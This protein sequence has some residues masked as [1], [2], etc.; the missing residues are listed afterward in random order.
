MRA[1]MMPENELR[2]HEETPPRVPRESEVACSG[3]SRGREGAG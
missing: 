3:R 1:K 2:D